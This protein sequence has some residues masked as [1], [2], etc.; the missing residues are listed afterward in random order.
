MKIHNSYR[1]AAIITLIFAVANMLNDFSFITLGVAL[2]VASPFL[3]YLRDRIRLRITYIVSVLLTSYSLYLMYHMALPIM[4]ANSLSDFEGP[5]GEGAPIAPIVAL[6]LYS[7]LFAYPWIRSLIYAA[8]LNHS[9]NKL[10]E[11]DAA[12]N[13]LPAGESD[14]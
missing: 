14:Q 13:H 7:F 4:N 9:K 11:Q 6:T 3:N 8:K 10:T 12:P 5:N 1:I 2:I